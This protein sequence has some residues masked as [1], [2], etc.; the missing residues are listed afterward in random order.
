MGFEPSTSLLKGEQSTTVLQPRPMSSSTTLFIES[1]T[2]SGEET[3][4]CHHRRHQ[5]GWNPRPARVSQPPPGPG[6]HGARDPLFR[7]EIPERTRLVRLQD[8]Q[9]GPRPIGDGENSW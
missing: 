9:G 3:S 5:E 1:G 8:A 4:G 7:Q 6:R 2:T